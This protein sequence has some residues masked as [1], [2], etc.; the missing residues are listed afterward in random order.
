MGVSESVGQSEK[1][2]LPRRVTQAEALNTTNRNAVC[3]QRDDTRVSGALCV[4]R[5][6]FAVGMLGSHEGVDSKE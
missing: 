1:S 3:E 4:S 6:E 2:L 5:W